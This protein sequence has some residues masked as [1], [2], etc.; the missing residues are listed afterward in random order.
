MKHLGV[1]Y[2]QVLEETENGGAGDILN[3][4]LHGPDGSPAPSWLKQ[5][6]PR[7][8]AGNPDAAE[9]MVDLILSVVQ[10]DGQVIDY[11]IRLDSFSGHLYQ[12][13]GPEDHGFEPRPAPMF[14]QQMLA[15]AR[16]GDIG[17]LERALGLR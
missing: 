2:L 6:G 14:S 17:A 15:G 12:P 5:L 1:I 9:G 10:R 3:Y 13:R 11:E 8:F 4:R 7:S 16:Q